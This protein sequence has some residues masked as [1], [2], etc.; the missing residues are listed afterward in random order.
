MPL[1]V[2]GLVHATDLDGGFIAW[3]AAGLPV[4]GGQAAIERLI[5]CFCDRV[6]LASQA[7]PDHRYR[8]PMAMTKMPT[9]RRMRVSGMRAWRRAPV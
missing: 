1:P 8:P 3:A 9:V 6:R 2:L 7:I 4:L 5:G